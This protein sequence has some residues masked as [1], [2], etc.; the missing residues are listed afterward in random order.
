[1]KTI[2][3]VGAG[4]A[5]LAAAKELRHSDAEV[6]VVDRANHNLFRS[7]LFPPEAN[8]RDRTR[9]S[10]HAEHKSRTPALESPL[11][12]LTRTAVGLIRWFT[13]GTV[14]CC[15][16]FCRGAAHSSAFA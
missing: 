10:V 3:I 6:F 9:L 2:V 5:G 4:F 12:R 15:A 7:A 16:G 11:L 14:S 8:L 1:M 13:A